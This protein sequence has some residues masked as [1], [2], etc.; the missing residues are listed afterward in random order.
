MF[1]T[2]SHLPPLIIHAYTLRC[3]SG[4]AFSSNGQALVGSNG[5][6]VLDTKCLKN[7]TIDTRK[8]TVTAYAGATWAQVS[9]SLY[10]QS[11]VLHISFSRFFTLYYNPLLQPTSLVTLG[12]L[13][14]SYYYPMCQVLDA[15]SVK[16]TRPYITPTYSALTVGGTVSL[17]GTGLLST[18]R[19]EKHYKRLEGL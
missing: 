7:I 6:I 3:R 13:L 18:R 5:G 9:C 16:N 1:F 11:T 2:L 8:N 17:G 19:G 10:I 4:Q 15:A 12:H 14:L